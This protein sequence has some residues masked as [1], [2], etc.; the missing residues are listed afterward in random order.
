M[1]NP[2]RV[3][4]FGDSVCVGQFCNP[5]QTWVTQ[6]SNY[7]FQ[8]SHGSSLV[9]NCSVNGNTTRMALERM[10]FEV[11]SHG[12]DILLIQFGLNDANYWKTDGGL[13]R[14]SP[15]AFEANL[16]EIIERGRR[17]G[18]QDIILNTNH[19]TP[20][21]NLLDYAPISFEDNNRAYNEII[22]SVARQASVTL[23]DMER[24]FLAIL[25][26]AKLTLTD[27]LL[28]DGIHLSVE[29]HRVYF[30]KIAPVLSKMAK[31]QLAEPAGVR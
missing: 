26:D 18:A 4:F 1:K 15:Q 25:Q 5:Q 23:V 9:S 21:V 3:C 17:F 2:L 30:E 28:P 19:P 22:R 16:C 20:K 29:G 8:L 24:V 10:P 27:L 12:V 31:K 6:L 13:P 7:L 11:Q 14:V